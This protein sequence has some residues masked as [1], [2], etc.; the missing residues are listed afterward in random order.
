[1]G[2]TRPRVRGHGEQCGNRLE[3]TLAELWCTE[4]PRTVWS[5][6]VFISN[7]KGMVINEFVNVEEAILIERELCCLCRL[8]RA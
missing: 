5:K 7:L 8:Y 6:L 2:I 3:L 1:M 4:T